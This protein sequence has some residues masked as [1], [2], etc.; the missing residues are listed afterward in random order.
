[1][2]KAVYEKLQ[3]VPSATKATMENWDFYIYFMSDQLML[4]T[5]EK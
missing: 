4:F 2:I 3:K 5:L 1:M